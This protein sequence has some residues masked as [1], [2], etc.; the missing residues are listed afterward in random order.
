MA[1]VMLFNG[2][3]WEP[4]DWDALAESVT[5]D[6]TL[7][8]PTIIEIEFPPG[9][10]ANKHKGFPFAYRDM[11]H[12]V[13]ED[14]KGG[15]YAGVVKESPL[16]DKA[17]IAAYGHSIY[18]ENTPWKS[19]ARRWT[20]MDTIYAFRHIWQRIIRDNDIPRLELRG[21]TRG[22]VRVGKPEDSGWRK[23]TD[24]IKQAQQFVNRRDNQ[25]SY[26]ERLQRTY[27]RKMFNA[28]GRTAVGEVV[29]KNG[30][31]DLKDAATN[32]AV[33]EYEG[34]SE[35]NIQAVSFWNWTGVGAGNWARRGTP[36]ILDWAR[37][38]IDAERS[39]K[40]RE[41]LYPTYE[42]RAKD[43][44]E[45]RDEKYPDGAAE[46]YEVNWWENRNLM[47]TLEELADLGG[48]DWYDTGRWVGDEFYPGIEVMVDDRPVRQDVHL[49]LGINIHE[50]PDIVP[51]EVATH[52]TALGSGEGSSTLRAERRMSH[53]RLVPVHRTVSSKDYRT[54]QL[55][56]RA[57]DAE[58]NRSRRALTP[59]LEGLTITDHPMAPI[60]SFQL[61]DR[62]PVV[63]TLADG[64][65]L[66]AVVR[67]ISIEQDL[68]G[69]AL[70]VEVEGI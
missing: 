31:V 12:V 64:S 30:K 48:F 13:V 5:V 24:R 2:K 52:V 7:N 61:G 42:Q 46:P 55:T 27:A 68:A 36:E 67:V 28:S 14:D 45:E 17:S 9:Y 18:S 40:R 63:G 47:D 38:W 23:L 44:T 32:K 35:Y 22:N 41:E 54:Q 50:L 6:R 53:N 15:T 43:L 62:I 3:D 65:D 59:Q 49:E 25:A 33:I 51:Q 4:L 19:D 70:S 60:S 56:D 8:A 11:T 21:A 57:A 69:N 20:D 29:L 66:D 1:R 10:N 26:F 39:K 58:M 16:T 37:K 34:Q